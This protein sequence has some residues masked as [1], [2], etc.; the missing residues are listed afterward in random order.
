MESAGAGGEPADRVTL[1]ESVSMAMLVVL[2][3]LSPAERSSF[4]LHDVFGYSFDEV[5]TIVGRSPAACRQLATRAR[6]RV[7]EQR[8]RYPAS[9]REQ[10]EIV[11][12]FARAAGNGDIGGLLGLLDPDV[13][14]RSDGG[15]LVPA[16]RAELRGADR[17]IRV[18]E[19]MARHYAGGYSITIVEVNGAA[20]L[21][22]ESEAG[23]SVVAL[24][25]DGGRVRTIDVIRNPDKLRHLPR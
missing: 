20:G 15:G 18:L 21:M 19:G 22:I 4:L 9:S 23:S 17:V 2:E 1:D 3:A 6:R 5:G 8:P 16:A 13:E 12:A 14:F 25:V 24:T 11:Q 7:E 10:R